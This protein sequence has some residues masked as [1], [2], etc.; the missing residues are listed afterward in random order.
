MPGIDEIKSSWADEVE[1]DSGI[2]PPPTET[3]ENGLKVLTEYKFNND[4]K[5]TKVVR[6]YKIMKLSV[7]KEVAR[8]KGLSKF[9]DSASDKP[10]P[11]PHTTM[12]S[13]DIHMQFIT[14]KEEEKS[15]DTTVDPTK[16]IAK[17][18]ICNADHWSVNCPYKGTSMESNMGKLNE[19]KPAVPE[20]AGSKPAKYV[21]PYMKDSAKAGGLASRLG[22]DD[23]TNIR[24]SN[25]SESMVEAD[26]EELVKKIGPHQKMYLARDRNTGLCKGFAYVTFK[27]RKD[28]ATAIQMLNGHGYDHL[29]LNVEWSKPQNQ[30]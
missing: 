3:I 7:P 2:L 18:R 23:C 25:L 20:P 11:C 21:P 16:T 28:A 10:G 1:L 17:C 5:K 15:A 22:R 24:I 4:D 6:T 13:E 12:V 29:I 27:N 19:T 14:N 26:L 8:R 9:G 30:N